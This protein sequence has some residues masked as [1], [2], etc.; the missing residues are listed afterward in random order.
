MAC[1]N[2]PMQHKSVC[3]NL[4]NTY[5]HATIYATH[6]CMHQSMQHI[7]AIVLHECICSS[8]H[9]CTHSRRSAFPPISHITRRCV[10]SHPCCTSARHCVCIPHIRASACRILRH[11]YSSPHCSMQPIRTNA[12]APVRTHAHIRAAPRS[13]PFRTSRVVVFIPAHAAH[14]RRS[15]APVT[16]LLR[17]ASHPFHRGPSDFHEF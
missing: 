9:S 10:H 1:I 12:F 8:S 7:Y 13:R 4:Y 6:L 15:V 17:R 14:P 5:L 3:T 16:Q 2:P 11:P